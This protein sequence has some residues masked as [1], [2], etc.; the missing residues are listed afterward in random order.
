MNGQPKL[1]MAN[2]LLADN[3]LNGVLINR[4]AITS[5]TDGEIR[6]SYVGAQLDPEVDPT[7]VMVRVRFEDNVRD[8]EVY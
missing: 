2:F 4:D 7:S 1:T 8:V 5:I 6:G 3:E